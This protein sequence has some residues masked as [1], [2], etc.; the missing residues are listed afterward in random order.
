MKN[1]P[2]YFKAFAFEI[3]TGTGIHTNRIDM[4]PFISNTVTGGDGIDL[5]LDLDT[6]N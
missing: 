2:D 4:T 1:I 5:V 6:A 3:L